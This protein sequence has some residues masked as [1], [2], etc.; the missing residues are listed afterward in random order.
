MKSL[1]IKAINILVHL[2]FTAALVAQLALIINSL[3]F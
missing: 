1:K 3:N 2:V